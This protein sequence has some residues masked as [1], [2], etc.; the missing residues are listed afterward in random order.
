MVDSGKNKGDFVAM[1]PIFVVFLKAVFHIV[2]KSVK[3]DKKY[4]PKNVKFCLKFT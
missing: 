1:K 3:N 4:V 2:P